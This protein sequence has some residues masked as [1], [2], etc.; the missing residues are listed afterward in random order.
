MDLGK[1]E[2]QTGEIYNFL[3]YEDEGKFGQKKNRI[4]EISRD[5]I[6]FANSIYGKK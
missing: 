5:S 2:A 4:S 3:T 6:D 1:T